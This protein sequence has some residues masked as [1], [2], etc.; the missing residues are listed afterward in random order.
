MVTTLLT[1]LKHG[2]TSLSFR[3]HGHPLFQLG[4]SC[5]AVCFS[6]RLRAFPSFL[7]TQAVI[8][9]LCP[10]VILPASRCTFSLDVVGGSM[11]LRICLPFLLWI[12]PGCF[13]LSQV[14]RLFPR[15]LTKPF[16]FLGGPTFESVLSAHPCS[17]SFVPFYPHTPPGVAHK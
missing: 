7:V 3:L 1:F 14:V 10:L 13:S 9:V 2:V 17:P 5:L 16:V 8:L 11:L 12:P 6:V 15:F 4:S